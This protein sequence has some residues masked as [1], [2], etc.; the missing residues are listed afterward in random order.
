MVIEMIIENSSYED[1]DQ[2]DLVEWRD[3]FG[4][5]MPVVSDEGSS[6]LDAHTSGSIGLPYMMLLNRGAV[7]DD[8]GNG[9]TVGDAERLAGLAE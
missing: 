4:L 9:I 8:M 5:T 2:D 6:Y 3:E 1:A 7:I